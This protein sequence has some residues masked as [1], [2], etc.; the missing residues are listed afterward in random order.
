M[1]MWKSTNRIPTFPHAFVLDEDQ[2]LHRRAEEQ[3]SR[4]TE[5]QKNVVVTP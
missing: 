3:K 2:P 5:E 4:R 1:E